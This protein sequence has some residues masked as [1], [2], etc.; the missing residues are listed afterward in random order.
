MS[1]TVLVAF[2]VSTVLASWLT[3]GN[4]G[5]LVLLVATAGCLAA[6]FMAPSDVRPFVWCGLLSLL[7][8]LGLIES[9]VTFTHGA[10]NSYESITHHADVFGGLASVVVPLFV[11]VGA[12]A[13]VA[14]ARRRCSIGGRLSEAEVPEAEHQT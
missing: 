2:A 5:L 6:L 9:Y 3:Q 8:A 7:V 10:A 13:G 12:T 4:A 1:D 11:A 14:V